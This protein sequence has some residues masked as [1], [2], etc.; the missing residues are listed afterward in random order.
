MEL[1]GEKQTSSYSPLTSFVISHL[2]KQ[3]DINFNE[4][5]GDGK[6]CWLKQLSFLVSYQKK[7]HSKLPLLLL[8]WLQYCAAVLGAITSSWERIFPSLPSPLHPASN[9]SL[10]DLTLLKCVNSSTFFFFFK[11]LEVS[12]KKNEPKR[13]QQ[14]FKTQASIFPSTWSLLTKIQ[15]LNNKTSKEIKIY[16]LPF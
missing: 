6:K 4:N 1:W 11:Q 8:T 12:G 15:T 13:K 2:T 7:M 16:Y 5:F 3:A 10:K 14:M 9:P